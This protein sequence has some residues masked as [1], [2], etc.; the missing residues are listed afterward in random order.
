MGLSLEFDAVGESSAI[1][2][3]GEKLEADLAQQVKLAVFAQLGVEVGDN[4]GV[5]YPKLQTPARSQSAAPA[6]SQNAP[7]G[8][9][10]G[11][12]GGGSQYGPPKVSREEMEAAPV[13]VINGHAY[14]DLRGFK[15]Q[16]KFSPRAADFRSV[17]EGTKNQEWLTSKDGQLNRDIVDALVA[18]GFDAEPF[19]AHTE[20]F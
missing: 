16:G 20:V 19:D 18:G 6:R 15:R 8:G 4:Q 11:G 5:L 13:V 7:T 9:Q 2:A 12:G 1:V 17:S 3:M 14:R 10:S